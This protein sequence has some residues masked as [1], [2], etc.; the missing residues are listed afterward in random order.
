MSTHENQNVNGSRS[1]L[2]M[3]LGMRGIRLMEVT[4]HRVMG[5]AH[6]LAP[7]LKSPEIW[8]T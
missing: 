7:N 2:Q 8:N 1:A 5:H 6:I 4:H 3:S